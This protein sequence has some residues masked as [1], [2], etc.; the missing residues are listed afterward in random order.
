MFNK[1]IKFS[2]LYILFICKR[3][4]NRKMDLLFEPNLTSLSKELINSIIDGSPMFYG[5]IVFCMQT[6]I[7][8]IAGEIQKR[9]PW[10]TQEQVEAGI[11]KMNELCGPN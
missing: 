10:Y 3:A 7:K 6:G 4:E 8:D 2:I 9:K 11:K 5:S 1:Y